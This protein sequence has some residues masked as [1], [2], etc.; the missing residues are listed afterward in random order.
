MSITPGP[1]K[2]AA[3]DKGLPTVPQSGSLSAA[4]SETR[5]ASA[6]R[7]RK[8]KDPLAT[9]DE[10]ACPSVSQGARVGREVVI[11]NEGFISDQSWNE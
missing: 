2:L 11:S 3:P 6:L 5:E 7:R 1:E 9:L 10:L 4:G 8:R